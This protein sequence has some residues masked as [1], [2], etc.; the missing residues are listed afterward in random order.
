MTRLSGDDP[1]I[2]AVFRAISRASLGSIAVTSAEQSEGATSVAVALACRSG[3]S[4][5]GRGTLIVDLDVERSEVAQEFGLP[6]GDG[7]IVEVAS[8]RVGVVSGIDR[9]TWLRWRE[10][11]RLIE[12]IAAWGEEWPLI[13]LDTAP[14]LSRDSHPVRAEAVAA[15]AEG[16]ILV[17]L[18]GRT[19]A[20]RVSE[21][22]QRLDAAGARLIGAVLNDAEAP[23]LA[24]ELQR[25]V[26]RL[27]RLM[28]RQTDKWGR[29]LG[30][31]ATL[32]MRI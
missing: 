3:A 8:A 5:T 21:A 14:L 19:V 7:S 12:Q 25:S 9:M 27:S 18:A 26:G 32:S 13:V 30:R 17:T 31:S 10:P 2:E 4:S 20:S 29:R 16:T 15:A 1:E 6:Q 22:R 11:A 23:P 28:P 24:V